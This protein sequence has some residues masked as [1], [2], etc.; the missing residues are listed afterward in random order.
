MNVMLTIGELKKRNAR[1]PFLQNSFYILSTHLLTSVMANNE[2]YLPRLNS[3]IDI[4][5]G[6]A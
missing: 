6:L 3:L 5:A 2:M 1:G 4:H